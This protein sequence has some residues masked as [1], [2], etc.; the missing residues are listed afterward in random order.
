MKIAANWP[1]NMS[2]LL[3]V[4]LNCHRCLKWSVLLHPFCFLVIENVRHQGCQRC[5]KIILENKILFWHHFLNWVI[6]FQIFIRTMES[7]VN[8]RNFT[9]LAE[10][11]LINRLF[12]W[13][14]FVPH[15][16]PSL[17]ALWSEKVTLEFFKADCDWQGFTRRDTADTHALPKAINIQSTQLQSIQGLN[18]FSLPLKQGFNTVC[19][20]LPFG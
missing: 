4:N 20:S 7:A 18:T 3:L 12:I 11:L 10:L 19:P 9:K 6:Y 14:E 2:M 17:V 8:W 15:L 13:F 5:K 1:V 16:P